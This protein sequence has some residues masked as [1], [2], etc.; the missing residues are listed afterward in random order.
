MSTSYSLIRAQQDQAAVEFG[1]MLRRW[2]VANGWT[3]YTA[4]RWADEA[5]HPTISCSGL[6]E[7]EQAKTKQP[8]AAVYLSL[9]ELNE[10]IAREDFTG[11]RSR[12]LR[13]QLEGSIPIAHEDGT[14]WGPEDFWACHTGLRAAPPYLAAPTAHP[15]P[16]LTDEQAAELCA[17]WAAQARQLVV[18][19]G[20]RPADLMRVGAAAPARFRD[21]W[22]AVALGLATW[23]PQELAEVWDQNANEWKPAAWLATWAESLPAPSGGGGGE[24][25]DYELSSC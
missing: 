23:S 21:G 25:R 10:R 16:E 17:G 6:S 19:R 9:A 2:R 14:P 20:G 15:C 3:Q 24:V 1:K 22:S 11:V 5:G 18:A 13:D 12:D 4:Q 8:R 7:L